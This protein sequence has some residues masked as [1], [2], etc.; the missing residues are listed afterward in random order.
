MQCALTATTLVAVLLLCGGGGVTSC[1][2]GRGSGQRRSPRKMTPLVF[3]QHSPNVPEHT[4]GASGLPEGRIARHSARFKQLVI[5]RNPDIVFKDEESTGA[6]RVMSKVRLYDV[7]IDG[8]TCIHSFVHLIH[9]LINSVSRSVCHS[10]SLSS[11]SFP[12]FPSTQ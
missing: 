2:P 9:Y 8:V 6:D 10:N 3:K 4:L 7:Q 5:N 12:S 1:G 11:T